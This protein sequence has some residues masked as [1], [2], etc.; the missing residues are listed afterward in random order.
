MKGLQ[1]L[2]LAAAVVAPF[3]QA[4]MASIDDVML[5]EMTGQSGITIDVDLQMTIAAIK[6]VD[7]DGLTGAGAV[8]MRNITVG[9]ITYN[10]GAVTATN[11]TGMVVGAA[12]IRGITID[13]DATK[14]L[15]IG[16][17]QIGDTAG[18]GIDINVGAVMINNGYAD[19]QIVA[20]LQGGATAEDAIR[21]ALDKNIGG[22]V[23]ENFRNYIQDD[24]VHKYNG[25]FGMDLTDANGVRTSAAGST[26]AETGRY[27]R[28]EIQIEGT[29][30]AYTN[31]ATGDFASAGLKITAAIGGAL[32]KAAWSDTDVTAGAT[33]GYGR[34]FGVKDIGFFKGADNLV[35]AN[36]APVALADNLS[37]TIEAMHFEVTINVVD[38]NTWDTGVEVAALELSGMKIDGTIML[39]DIYLSDNAGNGYTSLGSVLIKD[40]DMTGTNM[41][42]YGH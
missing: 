12:Q 16:L 7:Q 5:S 36:G 26:G 23:I 33:K 21:P 41:F 6:Y 14:G 24:L 28:G 34:Q 1:K 15:V 30:N 13:V 11:P 37:D 40:I 18:N 32:D 38:H 10:A 19:A 4:E 39:G 20:A 2:A 29:G 31:A 42:I 25:V 3:A 8:T 9:D 17:E 27:V 22:F 35:N